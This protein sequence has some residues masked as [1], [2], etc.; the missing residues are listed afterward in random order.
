[1][2]LL[3]PWVSLCAVKNFRWK[4]AGRD[5]KGQMRY[6]V[7]YV[8]VADGQAP[9]PEFMARLKDIKFD[10]VVSVHAEYKGVAAPELL[11]RAAGDLKY[12]KSLSG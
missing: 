2:D 4:D 5:D 7:E 9:I 10:G 1:M 3:A 8:S 12:L 11:E 6:G